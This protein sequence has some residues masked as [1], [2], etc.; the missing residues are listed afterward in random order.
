MPYNVLSTEFK[1]LIWLMYLRKSRQ[2]DPNETVEEVLAKHEAILQE[3]AR[4]ERP[5]PA[6]HNKRQPPCS[7]DR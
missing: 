4:R 6:H 2:D 5:Y 1:N 7:S 3:W